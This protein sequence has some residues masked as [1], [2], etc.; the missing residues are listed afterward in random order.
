M[1][2]ANEPDEREDTHLR[3]AELVRGLYNRPDAETVIAELAEHAAVEIP[4]AQYAGITIIRKSKTVETPAATHLYPMLLDK[5]QQRH[6]EGPCLTA[7]WD[8]KVVYVADLEIDDRFPGYR[9]DALAE[10]PIRS[11]MAFQLF[12]EGET[13]GALNVYSEKPDVFGDE[14]RSIGLVFAAH[15]SV[16]WNAA[17]RDQQFRQALASRDIIGQA[18]GMIM[19][20]YGVD[21]VQA[22][23]LLRKLSQDSNVP[24]IKVATEFVQKS[25]G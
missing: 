9:R 11:I 3:I 12:I 16:A 4:G 14:S 23:D 1:V 18:K 8:K 17:R 21:A 2:M 20:R 15:S 6:R 7:A 25:K 10:T 5:I 24:L 19:E 13:M 22:F